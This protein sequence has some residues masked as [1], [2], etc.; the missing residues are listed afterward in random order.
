M[1]DIAIIVEICQV[2]VRST[3]TLI[4]SP[5]GWQIFHV[6]KLPRQI[7][8]DANALATGESMFIYEILQL[9]QR[10]YTNQTQYTVITSSL[11]DKLFYTGRVLLWQLD[12]FSIPH[13]D[14][15]TVQ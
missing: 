10:N 12:F 3:V 8:L 15:N 11:A 14:L 4:I 2:I 7:F 6:A 5:I 9:L 1:F 13:K